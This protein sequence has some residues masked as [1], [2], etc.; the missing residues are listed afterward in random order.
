MKTRILMLTV[1]LLC[2]LSS[3]ML[4]KYARTALPSGPANHPLAYSGHIRMATNIDTMITTQYYEWGTELERPWRRMDVF[5]RSD[6]GLTDTVYRATPYETWEGIVPNRF[7]DDVQRYCLRFNEKNQMLSI[8]N[9]FSNGQLTGTSHEDFLYD[10]E[11]RLVRHMQ[12]WHDPE[13]TPS[14]E[15]VFL[16]TYDF[17]TLQL[18]EKGYIFEGAVYEFDGQGR[19]TFAALLDGKDEFVTL[20]G[21]EYLA[22]A[23]Y[24]TY[25]D[26]SYTKFSRVR[27]GEK[28]YG[29]PDLW[30][31]TVYVFYENGNE[32]SKTVKGSTDGLNWFIFEILEYGYI[33][34]N[35]SG[36]AQTYAGDGDV[37]NEISAQTGTAVYA[38]S[39][40]ILI[41]AE[42]AATVQIFDMAGR[43]VKQQTLPQGESRISIASAGLYFVKAGNETFKV[44]VR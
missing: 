32:K 13:K 3:D 29:W 22:G 25:T 38:L 12:T 27:T 31:E 16:K 43:L 14:G 33:Y 6:D 1:L 2:F 40:A 42:N 17:S 30:E 26:S 35:E 24:Y 20:D 23:D 15:V 10:E 44:Y 9:F 41:T 28:M 34:A 39:G 11:G 4:A 5:K 7:V 19:M 21:K 18:T 36:E 8:N 37:S